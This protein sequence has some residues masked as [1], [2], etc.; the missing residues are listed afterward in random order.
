MFFSAH[1]Y[2]Q[3]DCDAALD[4]VLLPP[5]DNILDHRRRE[6]TAE[7]LDS[8]GGGL[9]IITLDH[10]VYGSR[11]GDTKVFWSAD[12]HERSGVPRELSKQQLEPI[13]SFKSY[14][15]GGML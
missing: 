1:F 4:T 11:H 8:V 13:F 5:P 14:I 15:E 2:S 9:E 3:P 12:K 7:I 6:K 10:I